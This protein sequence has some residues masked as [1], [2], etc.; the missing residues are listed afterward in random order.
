MY[1][2]S[3]HKIQRLELVSCAKGLEPQH[4]LRSSPVCG[5]VV[6]RIPTVNDQEVARFLKMVRCLL[7]C[8][9]CMQMINKGS[10]PCRLVVQLLC[11]R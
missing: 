4:V 8:A 9:A 7:C 10:Y 11:L 5:C 2:L 1:C 3:G 6:G